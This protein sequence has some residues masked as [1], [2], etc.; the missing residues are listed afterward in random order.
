ML[1][2]SPSSNLDREGDQALIQAI[3]F[4]KSKGSSIILIAHQKHLVDIAD[5]V[6]VLIEGQ[7]KLFG[8]KNDVLAA[9]QNQP[10][11]KA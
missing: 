10:S 11:G 5:Q 6:L 9:L 7:N 4:L 1:F 3:N 8:P 2:R